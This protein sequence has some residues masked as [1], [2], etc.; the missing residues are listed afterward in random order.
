MSESMKIVCLGDSITWGFPVGPSVSWVKSLQE[1]LGVEII[2]KGING[3]TTSD[4]LRRFDQAV[5]SYKPSHVIIMG[6]AN[7]I[8]MAESFDRIVTNIRL[9]DEKAEENG[10]KTVF[11]LP[12]PIDDRYLEDLLARI[13]DWMRNYAELK[14]IPVIAFNRA[15][16][17]EKGRL[18]TELLLLDGAHPAEEGYQE[19]FK[20]IDLHIFE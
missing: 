8:L 14:N 6:G 12:T 15:F 2:N 1:S 5:L 16:Y 17:D 18:R 9:M 19:M 20:Q 13:R 7:D 11:G 4:M 3:N 10:I